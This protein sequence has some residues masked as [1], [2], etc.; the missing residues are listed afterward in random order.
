MTKDL[1]LKRLSRTHVALIRDEP[2]SV[3]S[4][5]TLADDLDRFGTSSSQFH[6]RQIR[7][8]QADRACLERELKIAIARLDQDDGKEAE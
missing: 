8:C 3:K 4:I 5:D 2:V 7:R 6:A 1:L